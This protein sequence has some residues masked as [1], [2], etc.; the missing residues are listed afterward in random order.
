MQTLKD[1]EYYSLYK[2]ELARYGPADCEVGHFYSHKHPLATFVNHLV[3]SRILDKEVRSLRNHEFWLITESGEQR[4]LIEGGAQLQGI[5][6]N[7]FGIRVTEAEAR[8]LFDKTS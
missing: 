8:R 6:N 7:Q 1:G 2:F 5:L 3:V 4:Q